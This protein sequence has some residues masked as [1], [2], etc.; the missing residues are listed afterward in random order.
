MI[1]EQRR[2]NIE[3]Q[4]RTAAF[5]AWQIRDFEKPV[6]FEQYLSSMGLGDKPVGLTKEDLARLTKRA[7]DEARKAEI[8]FSKG[9]KKV[10]L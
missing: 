5:I 3:N 10:E 4:M 8:A 2:E 9:F 6:P 7:L 1:Q